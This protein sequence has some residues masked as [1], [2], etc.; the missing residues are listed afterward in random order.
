MIKATFDD[1]SRSINSPGL[2]F[3][4]AYDRLN[5]A[6]DKCLNKKPWEFGVDGDF[7]FAFRKLEDTYIIFG[8]ASGHFDYAGGIKLFVAMALQRVLSSGSL[9]KAPTALKLVKGLAAEFTRIGRSALK[10]NVDEPLVDGAS[11][12][13]VHINS[14]KREA[15]FVSA[16]IPVRAV[17]LD[18]VSVPYG[19]MIDGL[20]ILSFPEQLVDD[21][22]MKMDSGKLPVEH[23][24]YLVF[25]TDGFEKLGRSKR[26]GALKPTQKMGPGGIDQ[27]LLSVFQDRSKKPLPK[28]SEL[29]KA[30][31]QHARRWRNNHFIPEIA[32]DDRLVLA[33]DLRRLL[34]APPSKKK[35]KRL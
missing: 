7:Y 27:A 22:K 28:A 4:H 13:A 32:D 33:L 3:A 20:K 24:P 30:V 5:P 35:I 1:I 16:G 14:R 31:V 18:G 2:P 25:V 26:K 17:G 9:G 8:D 12:V 21:R 34:G 29:V 6:K 15:D 10:S 19:K 11:V 23:N